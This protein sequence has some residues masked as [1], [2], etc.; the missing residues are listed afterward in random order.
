M[1]QPQGYYPITQ[2]CLV[3]VQHRA[4]VRW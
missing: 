4:S 2:K 3:I 1:V